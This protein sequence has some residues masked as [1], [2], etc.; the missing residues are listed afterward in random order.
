VGQPIGGEEAEGSEGCEELAG[1][2]RL[3]RFS[4]WCPK[5]MASIGRLP[6]TLS[7][8][9]IVV[10]MQ[11]RTQREECERLRDLDA[12][13]IR[14]QCLR[15]V[16]DHSE[17]IRVARPEIPKGLNDRA[18]DVWEPLLA[19]ADLAGAHWPGAAREA[20]MQLA[21]AT[22]EQNPM[23]SLLLN[24]FLIFKTREKDRLYT[25]ELVEG[26]AGYADRPWGEMLRG[27]PMTERWLA[28]KLRPYGVLPR[29]IKLEGSRGRGYVEADLMETFR[30]YIP[31]SEIEALNREVAEGENEE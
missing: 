3:A 21:Q 27:R 16:L 8:R 7:D 22:Q 31:K 25:R 10:W 6:D 15:F 29:V 14:R 2:A 9:C 20:A 30:R 5:I 23:G 24:I 1:A 11:R 4:C 19:L 13:S 26:L 18:G 28:L 17:E 12:G